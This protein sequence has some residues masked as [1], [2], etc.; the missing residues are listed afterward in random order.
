MTRFTDVYTLPDLLARAAVR[1]PEADAIVFPSRRLSYAELDTR[2]TEVARSLHSM[3]IRKG[4][5]VGI[6]MANSLEYV[7]LFLGI[8]LLGAWVVPINSRYKARELA[9]VVEN[10]D[11]ALLFTTDAIDEYVDFVEL[12]SEALPRLAEATDPE[13]LSLETAPLL[14]SIVLIGA[15]TPRGM[16]SQARFQ[17]LAAATPRE[18]IETARSRVAIRDVALMMYTSGTTAM[19]KGCPLSHEALVR[20]ALEAGRTRFLVGPEDRMWDPLPMF[21]M[22]F[23]LPLLA[24]MDAGASLLSMERFEPA[25]ALKY[26]ESEQ[27]SLSFAS[28][29]TITQALLSHPE[30]DPTKLHFRLVN[31]VAPP[32]TLRAM[33]S[34]MPFAVQISAY[35]LTEAGGVTAFGSPDDSLE[36]R[37]TTSGRPFRGIEVEIRDLE[38]G[39]PLLT[40]QRGEICIRGYCL[41]EGYYKDPEKTAATIEPDGWFHTGDLGCVNEEGYISYVGR[42]KDMLKVGGENVAAA[43]IESYLGTHPAV[44]IAQVVGV[45]DAKYDEVPAA[46]VELRP[47][48]STSEQELID[49]C[50]G[51]IASF[52]VPRHVRFVDEWPMSATKIQKFR[53]RERMRA[54]LDE[55]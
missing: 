14:R 9:Y 15:K 52:K 51:E 12:L 11:L 44:L 54:E 3:G 25:E 5:H 31:N 23:V 41:F 33:Q 17:S 2:A 26:M 45:P 19:P 37:T 4:D 29:P 34:A 47:G 36:L 20:T 53:L 8:A 28:F 7:E 30:Y 32:D 22:S 35:G 40:G 21:H 55:S 18:A 16:V 27:A 49:F 13:A 6:L 39:E 24:V 1:S 50:R 48:A 43:E 46:F 38:T 10:A 42:T